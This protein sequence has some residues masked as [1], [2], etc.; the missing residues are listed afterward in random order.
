MEN[1]NSPKARVLRAASFVVPEGTQVEV[2]GTRV[3]GQYGGYYL[4]EASANDRV[5]ARCRHRDWRKAYKGLEIELC[6]QA[7][8]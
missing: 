7:V 2:R 1:K 3:R 5:L 4:A 8:L 6:R